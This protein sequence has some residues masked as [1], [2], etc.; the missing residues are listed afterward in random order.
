MARLG[1]RAKIF[2]PRK[3]FWRHRSTRIPLRPSLAA[4]TRQTP[5]RGCGVDRRRGGRRSPP[6][7]TVPS[8][9]LSLTTCSPRLSG[10]RSHTMRRMMLVRAGAGQPAAV[11]S[12]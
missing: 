12:A 2:V 7:S 10:K 6:L 5:T 4:R 1:T 11:T 8:H 3:P 9:G